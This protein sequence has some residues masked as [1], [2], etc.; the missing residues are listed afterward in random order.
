MTDSRER[1]LDLMKRE[2][3]K[4]DL[5]DLDF[6]IYRILS[7]RRAEIEAFF[8]E[9]LPDLLDQAIS[10]EGEQRRT[11]LVNQLEELRTS[12]E[13]A[14]ADLGYATAFSDG[15]IRN[16]LEKTPKAQKYL[17]TQNAVASL[18]EGD[19]FSQSEEDRLYNVL[20][21][22]FSRYYRDGDFQPQQ[23]RARQARYSV[24]TAVKT[25]I[26][27]GDQR[28]LTTSRQP[29]SSGLT[30]SGLVNGRCGSNSSR[31]SKNQTM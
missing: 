15:A 5:A 27:T 9:E 25:S 16:E 29:K 19:V 6:G 12:L 18:D 14:A 31:R 17:E 24:H 2:I 11:E 22:F 28:A 8:D 10:G 4:L 1:F 26:S 13:E 3:L 30:R 20:Y 7:H 21:T 23:R